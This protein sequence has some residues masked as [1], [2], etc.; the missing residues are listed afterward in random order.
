MGSS[1]RERRV[2]CEENFLQRNMIG[3]LVGQGVKKSASFSITLSYLQS[4]YE[5]I[6]SYFR[7]LSKCTYPPSTCIS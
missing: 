7:L 3:R 5:T 6:T 2:P 4:I 1:I